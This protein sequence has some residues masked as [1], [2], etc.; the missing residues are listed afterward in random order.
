MSQK[1]Q[2]FFVNHWKVV[3]FVS[4]IVGTLISDGTIRRR[5]K[6]YGAGLM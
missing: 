4:E 6:R 5:T 3:D 2:H 1:S